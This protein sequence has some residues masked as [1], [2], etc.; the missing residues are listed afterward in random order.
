[1]SA[2]ELADLLGIE[3]T[4]ASTRLINLHRLRLV[5]RRERTMEEGGREFVYEALPRSPDGVAGGT[6]DA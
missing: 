4:A 3:L 1:M 5:T 2:R 6:P